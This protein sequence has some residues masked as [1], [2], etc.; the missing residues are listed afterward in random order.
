MAEK[1]I[2]N[3]SGFRSRL[4][5]WGLGALFPVMPIER[6]LGRP[7]TESTIVDITCDSDG[8]VSK[9][10]DLADVRDTLPLHAFDGKPYHLGIFLTGAYQ[11]IMGDIHNL[12]GRVN[13]VHVLPLIHLSE[14][15]GLRRIAD[16][17]FC[18]KNKIEL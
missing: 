15:T 8:K 3:S 5:H 11:D 16:A 1:S 7:T 2:C 9:F 12:F 13:E 4:D 14:P 17:V 6:L 18:C 10:I